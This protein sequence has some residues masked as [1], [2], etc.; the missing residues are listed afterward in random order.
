MSKGLTT[1][2]PIGCPDGI[3]LS[4]ALLQKGVSVY[5]PRSLYTILARPAIST[6]LSANGNG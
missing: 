4:G 1:P 2:Q 3:N 5:K 6:T